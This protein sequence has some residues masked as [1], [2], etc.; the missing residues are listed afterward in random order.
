M[1]DPSDGTTALALITGHIAECTQAR[2]DTKEAIKDVRNLLITFIGAVMLVV[3]TF[4]GYTYVQQQSLE[5]QA[6]AAQAATLNAIA[7]SHNDTVRAINET[8]D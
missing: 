1:G 6:Q 8:K 2:I 7:Q 4:A 3:V 5:H